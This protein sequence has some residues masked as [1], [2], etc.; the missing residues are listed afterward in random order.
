MDVLSGAETTGKQRFY[1]L[2]SAFQMVLSSPQAADVALM[3]ARRSLSIRQ[4]PIANLMPI[5]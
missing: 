3:T 5:G 1:E 2:F 4:S